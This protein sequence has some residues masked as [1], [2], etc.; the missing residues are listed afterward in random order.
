M[1]N[2]LENFYGLNPWTCAIGIVSQVDLWQKEANVHGAVW[3][4]CEG[5]IRKS[6]RLAN[7][8]PPNFRLV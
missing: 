3:I 5:K 1:Q 6:G 2:D 7:V 8:F 4:L